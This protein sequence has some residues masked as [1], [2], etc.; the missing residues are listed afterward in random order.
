MKNKKFIFLSAITFALLNFSCIVHNAPAKISTAV[1]DTSTTKAARD[2]FK[3]NLYENVI[4]HNLSLPLSDS[5]EKNWEEAFDG[6]EISLDNSSAYVPQFKKAF[7][8]FGSRSLEFQRS[9]LEALY[10]L[11]PDNFPQEVFKVVRSTSNAKI[12]AMGIN[13]LIRNKSFNNK[14]R[15]FI[16]L[17]EKKFPGWNGNPILLSLQTYLKNPA[18][19]FVDKRPPLVDLLSKNYGPD[20]TIIFSFQRTDRNYPG[21]AVIRRPDGSFVRN[22]DGTIF[23]ITQLARARTNLPY[24]LTNGN[25]PQGIFS[26]QG[27]D[28]SKLVDIGRTPNI[29]LVMPYEATPALFFHKDNPGDTAWTQQ[30]YS[31]ILPASWRGY[32]PIWGTYYA[33]KAGRTAIIAHGTT[34]DPS[35]YYGQPYYP[36]TPTLGCLCAGEI[37][38]EFDGSRL[39]SNQAALFNAFV[40]T[41][42][43]KGFYVVVNI[44]DKKMPVVIDDVIMDILKAEKISLGKNK[45]VY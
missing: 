19:K 23:Y 4:G 35:F 33:G 42:S 43:L 13:Y 17:I 31:N 12:F 11:Y 7:D 6:M 22:G 25:T 38:S 45:N 18:G 32:F 39:V 2:F 40:S 5:T 28:T 14:N 30:L 36:N 15:F 26:I 3:K 41:G 37:W 20:N 27:V 1:I 44:D 10:A 34:I 16:N 21:I 9:F 29:Q 8:S 24:Y